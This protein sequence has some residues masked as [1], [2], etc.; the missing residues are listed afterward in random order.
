MES[1][2]GNT[3]GNSNIKDNNNF[4]SITTSNVT[5]VTCKGT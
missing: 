4:R 1:N 5:T 2:M 3:I